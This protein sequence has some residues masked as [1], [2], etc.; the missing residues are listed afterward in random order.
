VTAAHSPP[1]PRVYSL[2]QV[3]A[4]AARL[5]PPEHEVN[6]VLR[7]IPSEVSGSDLEFVARI[8]LPL[9]EVA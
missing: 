3:K 2:E 1:M 7:R 4:S 8:V 6:V 5:Y 9:L